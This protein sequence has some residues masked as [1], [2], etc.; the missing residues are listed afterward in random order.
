ML[1]EDLHHRLIEHGHAGKIAIVHGNIEFS[2][3]YLVQAIENAYVIQQ[4]DGLC[5]KVV[6]LR[7]DF[8]IDA[9]AVL[10]AAVMNKNIVVPVTNSSL[11]DEHIGCIVNAEWLCT[12]SGNTVKYSELIGGKH[13]KSLIS[14]VLATGEGGLVF[15]SSGT[16]GKPKAVLHSASRF[17]EKYRTSRRDYRTLA[18]M[19]FDHIAGIDTLLYTIAAGGALIIPENRSVAQI[20]R[21]LDKQRVEVFPTSPSFLNHML[22]Y[23]GFN[24]E[25]LH[26]LKIITFG[27]ERMPDSLL[28]RLRSHIPEHVKLIQ[29]FGITEIGSPNVKSCPEDPLWFKFTSNNLEHRIVDNILHIK[30]E[31]SMIGYLHENADSPFNGWFNT[32][33]IVE[34]KGEWL[35][36]LGRETDLINVGGQKVYPAEVESLLLEME[37]IIDARVFGVDNALLGYVVGAEIVLGV[38]EKAVDIKSKIRSYLKRRIEPYKI[39]IYI[40]VTKTI[41]V[42]GRFKKDRKSAW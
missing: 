17:L 10:L 27:S 31:N 42:S 23:E 12:V 35:K 32:H 4:D 18:F 37:D 16:T 34:S 39:P 29:K 21:E 7:S 25:L 9:I 2:Y 5:R 38:P 28:Q 19:L 6:I 20:A 14:E 8:C 15:L 1:I 24:P 30:Y 3:S 41:K 40:R 36:V 26:H 11:S 22:H 13:N 33:D